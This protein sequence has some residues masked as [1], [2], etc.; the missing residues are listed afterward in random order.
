MISIDRMHEML[1]EIAAG[2]PDAFYEKLN[3]GISLLPEAKVSPHAR[4]ND[5]YILGEYH[6][7]AMGRYI[8]IYY[9]SFTRAHRH[10]SEPEIYEELRK[11]VAHEFTHHL[12]DLAGER[13]LEI[14][15][16]DDLMDYL[17]PDEYDD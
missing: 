7:N 14:Q 4:A 10:L 12:E 3:G 11:T 6:R 8:Y 2:F 17:Y 9:G 16:E 13:G 5:L 1:E 15:D